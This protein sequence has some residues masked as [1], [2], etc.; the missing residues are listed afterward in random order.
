MGRI[1]GL[2]ETA[3]EALRRARKREKLGQAYVAG[4]LGISPGYLH[5]VET[6]RRPFPKKRLPL[7]PPRLRSDVTQALLAEIDQLRSDVER[8]GDA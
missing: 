2:M 7:L 1:S 6:G 4:E 3:G 5:D 8:V